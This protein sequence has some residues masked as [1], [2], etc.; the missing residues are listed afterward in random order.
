VA[1]SLPQLVGF[2]FPN[3]PAGAANAG[4]TSGNG[5][6]PGGN[7]YTPSWPAYTTPG[8]ATIAA[9]RGISWPYWMPVDISPNPPTEDFDG[10]A[11]DPITGQQIARGK[12]VRVRFTDATYAPPSTSAPNGGSFW[13]PWHPN[14][15]WLLE[16]I[17]L[18]RA[19]DGSPLVL[20]QLGRNAYAFLNNLSPESLLA[21]QSAFNNSGTAGQGNLGVQQL[22]G[23]TP[24][25]NMTAIRKL[26]NP[27][28]ER[29]TKSDTDTYNATLG[30]RGRFGTD[31]TWD[32]YYQYGGTDSTSRQF[33]VA[34]NLRMAFA[35]D[36]VIDDRK[37][38]ADGVTPNPAYG[39]PI[40]R[41]NR[42][43]VPLL[44][45][46]GRPLTDP[47]GL[48]ALGGGCKPLNIF[49]TTYANQETFGDTYPAYN[50]IY[51]DAAELQRQALEYAFVDSRSSGNVTLQTLAANTSGTVWQGWGAGPLTAALGFEMRENK[52]DNEGTKGGF[53]E[54]ADLASVWADAFGGTTRVTEAY[55]E[56]NLPLVSGQDGINMLAVNAA[57]RYGW[58]HNK[59]GAGTTGESA[60]QRTPNWKFSATFEPFDW[61]R[62]R[63]TRSRDLRA[64]DYRELF[65]FQPGT[66][67]EFTIRNPWRAGT[68][69]S[70]ENQQELYGQV[71]VGNADLKPERSDTLTMGFVLSPGGWAQ[72]MR[73]SVDYFDIGV[74]DGINTPFNA[75]NPV[76]ACFEGSNGGLTS[77]YFNQSGETPLPPNLALAPCRELTF[78]TALDP[79]GNPIPGQV[80]LQD[81]VSYNSARP[82][83]SL[84]YQRRGLDFN[85]SYNFPLNRAFESLPGS[86]ALN[87]RATRAME[88][89]G[90]Q[91]SSNALGYYGDNP[92]GACG[93]KWDAADRFN[94]ENNDLSRPLRSN[95]LGTYVVNR[96]TCVDLVGQIRSSVFIPG[97]AASPTWSGNVTASYLLGNLTT[98][99][100]MRYIGGARFDNTWIDDPS[101][102]GYYAANGLPSN[103]SVDNNKVK[104]YARFDLTGSY[105][106]QIPN[107][108]QFRIFGSIT[109]LMDK[110]PPFTGGGISGATAGYHDTL[111]RSYRLGIQT[112]F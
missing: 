49:G 47:A 85:V 35:L 52:T 92:S 78:A 26:W 30:A 9:G 79:N 1:N 22:Y 7:P 39:T 18:L 102:P 11:R 13:T 68:A 19:F 88:S 25:S 72:G 4:F 51:Y 94:H 44:N 21:V 64:A 57:L 81:L 108:R 109:N 90:V 105:N 53:Y 84:P 62:L 20:P 110:T 96:Y 60:T 3:G 42:D 104:S 40:C 27:Q 45:G 50:G 32:T 66:P 38:L 89:S 77:D 69:T 100:L 75:S 99:V 48:T 65:L 95:V 87:V 37:F 93:A 2:L 41:I 55:T 80:N 71:R 70:N 36:S 16:S 58:Y 6:G 67:D 86:M 8:G 14:D 111:G 46:Q 97:V 10:K 82:A 31:W 33:N 76:T 103:A 34:S 23:A 59:G 28:I 73:L 74:K 98:S 107:M 29:S 101:Q 43:S 106:L 63:L 61:M 83:N 91:Q 5:I 24:C 54:R 56:L 17:E 15:Y 112:Q 12:W